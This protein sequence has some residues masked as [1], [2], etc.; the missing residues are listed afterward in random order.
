MRCT[1]WVMAL[2]VVST[3]SSR[4][5]LASTFDSI[6]LGSA[7]GSPGV[8]SVPGDRDLLGVVPRTVAL[9][10]ALAR[11]AA[12]EAQPA[13]L[14]ASP[15]W[16]YESNV[17]FRTL[18]QSVA[19]AGDINGDGYS[20]VVALGS[21]SPNDVLYVFMG[22]ATGLVLAPGYPLTNLPQST[23]G[24]S[25]CGAGDVNGDGFADVAVG[26]DR[27]AAGNFRLYYGS[28]GGLQATGFF[29]QAAIGG[30]YADHVRPAGDVNGDGYD[31][32]LVGS[33]HAPASLFYCGSSTANTG[34]VEIYYGSSTGLIYSN[35]QIALGCQVVSANSGFGAAISTAGDINADGYDDILIGAYGVDL[36]FV[37]VVGAVWVGYGSPSGLPTSSGLISY[38]GMPRIDGHNVGGLFGAS[39]SAAGDLNADGYAD[40]AVGAPNDGTYGSGSGIARVFK[41]GA[42]GVDTATTLWFESSGVVNGH[43]GTSITP[44]GDQNGD[45]R[46]DLLV[47]EATRIDL[48]TGVNPPIGAFISQ[49]L[50]YDVPT[51]FQCETA[52][53][54]NGDGMSDM[55]VGE[56]GYSNGEALEGR[57]L[58]HYGGGDGPA[59]SASWEITTALTN[60][61]FGWSV[62]SVG[63]LNGDGLDD[64]AVGSPSWDNFSTFENDCGMVLVYYGTLTGPSTTYDWWYF[65]SSGDGVG[66]SV[67][68]AGDVNG[69]GFGD[70][71]VGA[72]QPGAGNGKALVWYGHSTGPSVSPDRVL[73]GATFDAH[74]G[75][76]VA[77]AGDV[78]GDGY[79]DVAV[80]APLDED[81]TVL[82]TPLSGEGRAFLYLGSAGGLATSPVW[83]DRGGQVDAHYGSTV[84][85]IG[86]ANGD[87]FS[88]LAVT[89]PDFDTKSGPITI[90]DTGRLWIFSG[91]PGATPLLFHSTLTGPVSGRFGHSAAGAGDVNGD[92]YSDLV[93]G[94]P[95]WN[96]QGWAAVYGGSSS[97]ISAAGLW[98]QAGVEAFGGYGSSVSSAGDINGDGLS[99]VLIGASFQDAG[100]AQDRGHAAIYLG[101]L[102]GGATPAW[103]VYGPGI[104]ANLGHCVANAGDTDGDGWNELLFGMPGYTNS[105]SGQGL[106]R[107]FRGAQGTAVPLRSFAYRPLAGKLIQP[108]GLTDPNLVA[109]GLTGR[110]AAG[111]TRVRVEW[112]VRPA[113]GLAVPTLSGLGSYVATGVPGTY[114]SVASLT[115]GENRLV[116]GIPYSWQ[117]RSRSHSVYF[118]FSTW[119]SPTRS[120]AREWDMRAPGNWVDVPTAAHASELELAEAFPNPMR[121]SSLI[122]FQLSRGGPVVATIVDLQGRQVRELVRGTQRAGS[123][124]LSWDGRDQS[125][126]M[127]SAGLYFIRLDAEGRRLSRKLTLLR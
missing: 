44:A 98:S 89:A 75:S 9:E 83:S 66:I 23:N 101:P 90:A 14:A 18:G 25:V 63:D 86:D 21:A 2:M 93:V 84:V 1:R 71:V 26:L 36:Q 116:N 115:V 55:V 70:L 5:A 78:N 67:A 46:P 62:A 45:G 35:R 111:K 12:R 110:S 94:A 97:G 38:F 34:A 43:M 29:E 114:G 72:H 73:T 10:S 33:S 56:W 53:D 8:P 31:D 124:E 15:G 103:D 123:H 4:P 41:G 54:V 3:V 64:I 28:A 22:G 60:P 52:G 79:A 118:P 81:L 47:G 99:D 107:L 102:P 91:R 16:S 50:P 126:Q 13:K 122:R 104:F 48:V 6:A 68:S 30:G 24:L 112:R 88:D 117:L 92:G 108:L 82:P 76:S 20:D 80:G 121:S 7:L 37:G 42:A 127:S 125:G 17:A 119:Q 27:G 74:F 51:H 32:V 87:G 85:S 96:T 100:G 49:T 105:F 19:T 106:A 69:D 57:L 59:P 11:S 120:A 77:C 95:N 65:G 61:Y 109:I 58:V 113:I 40:I 39:V